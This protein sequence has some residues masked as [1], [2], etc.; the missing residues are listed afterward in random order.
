MS[1]LWRKRLVVK[2]HG[3][4]LKI[5]IWL[6][7]S[8]DLSTPQFINTHTAWFLALTDFI[9]FTQDSLVLMYVVGAC[10]RYKLHLCEAKRSLA[11]L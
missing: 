5:Y 11:Q 7:K 8:S 10:R 6:D 1:Y 2:G 3:C 4:V 9:V